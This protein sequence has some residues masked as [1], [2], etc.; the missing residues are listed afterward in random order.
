MIPDLEG[1]SAR[2]RLRTSVTMRGCVRAPTEQ[3]RDAAEEFPRHE[4][5]AGGVPMTV[6][7]EKE[8]RPVGSSPTWAPLVFDIP[9]LI[10]R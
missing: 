7:L 10:G 3:G 8:L 1:S 9:L 2:L 6:A 4:I 5:V